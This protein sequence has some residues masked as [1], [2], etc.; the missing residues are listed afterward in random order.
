V[1]N[2]H[3][4]LTATNCT[5]SGNTAQDAGGGVDSFKNAN[6]NFT[7]CLIGNNTAAMQGGGVYSGNYS[8]TVLSN[9][10]IM[11]DSSV[12]FGGGG[13]AANESTVNLYTSV[14]SGNSLTD[15][16]GAGIYGISSTISATDCSFDG[17]S[18]AY[19]G[20]AID[21]EG[22]VLSLTNCAVVG[23]SISD[24][25]GASGIALYSSAT[26]T[27]ND[28]TFTANDSAAYGG[29]ALLL[30]GG[31]TC[32][33]NNSILWND[34]SYGYDGMSFNEIAQIS[35]SVTTNHDDIGQSGFAGANGDIDANPLFVRNPN[36]AG[37]DYGDLDLRSPSPCID[38]GDTSAVPSGI[39]S[40]LAGN[41]RVV[42]S[43][44]DIG[45]LEYQGS[46]VGSVASFSTAKTGSLVSS[47]TIAMNPQ[48][49]SES[50]TLERA[51]GT[52]MPVQLAV[53]GIQTFQLTFPSSLSSMYPSNAL[54]AGLY[55]LTVT[56]NGIGGEKEYFIIHSG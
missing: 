38:A 21:L 6:S 42:G 16:P 18:A 30:A 23:N 4:N 41:P 15:A 28:S 7:G 33:L 48:A 14:V 9:C 54:P 25:Y 51:D 35:G 12:E 24:W 47:L 32:E 39:T 5:I 55:L 50:F 56:V 3:S 11:G 26:A 1:Y 31:S 34:S 20:G 19:G 40:D 52:S 44:V 8:T 45:A 13:V 29:G 17:D 2:Q 36:L 10:T 53:T 49:T 46:A 22:G 37:G 27:I 43:A